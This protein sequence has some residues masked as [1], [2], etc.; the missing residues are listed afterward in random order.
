[1]VDIE[2][3]ASEIRRGKK[4]KERR[5]KETT[6]QKYNGLFHRAAITRSTGTVHTSAKA[7]LASVA[8]WIP[9]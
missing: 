3:V 1:M 5:K 4:K 2:S 7:R 9:I 6:A 8:I